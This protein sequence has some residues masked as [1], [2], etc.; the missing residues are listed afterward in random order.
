MK[1]LKRVLPIA[2]ATVMLCGCTSI[3]SGKGNAKNSQKFDKEVDVLVVG[4]GIA[5]LSAAVE[6]ADQGC[7][8][9]LVVEKMPVV[10]GSAFISD[11]IIAAHNSKMAK[12]QG[13][14]VT[15][16]DCYNYQMENKKYTI[17]AEMTKLT[18]EKA[19]ESIDWLM[20]VVKVP[21]EPEVQFKLGYSDLTINHIVEGG[22][23]GLREP[24]EKAL[25]ERTAIEL[26]TEAPATELIT[27]ENRN[28]IGAVVKTK[29]GEIRV[30]AKATILTTGGY[31]S[32]KDLFTRLY[33]KHE[34]VQEGTLAWAKGD[35]LIMASDLGAG[36][37]NGDAIQCYLREYEDKT[38]YT[39]N[40][41]N[42]FV[43]KDGT[44][45]MDERRVRQTFNKEIYED[46]VNQMYKDGVDYYWGIADHGTLSKFK[47][48]EEAKNKEGVFVADTLE[49][50]AEKIG[51]NPEGLVKTVANWNDMVAKGV[52]TEFGRTAMMMP[53]GEGPYYA[54]K[55][56]L[57]P[58][59]GHG[60]LMRNDKSEVIKITGESIPGLYAAGEVTG[61]A[62][63]N[64]YTISHC[65]TWG[66]IAAQ[67][68]AK[69]AKEG[70]A[71][72]TDKEGAG[73]E[74][75][76]ENEGEKLELKDGTYKGS[77]KGNGG[78]IAVEVVVEKSAIKD[79]KILEHKETEGLADPA[80]ERIPKAIIEAQSLEVDTVAGATV[81]SNAIKEAVKAA[82]GI[83]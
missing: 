82:L 36:I 25:K 83:K 69:Y 77:A 16:E 46:T 78:D 56:T 72:K 32:N 2:L 48:A 28:V 15:F 68:A 31:S 67:N 4:A 70:P 44:R 64:G 45:F 18:T 54:I 41:Y 37:V 27:D 26:M 23:K 3:G 22:G 14:D 35:G 66:R 7:E 76:K 57:S 24:F 29:D 50:L 10:G 13:I 52:D 75:K 65:I 55:S 21:F 47:I 81:T 6:L 1:I 20:D 11:G 49:E 73:E 79:I 42:I 8:N 59:L 74:E 9:V 80:L 51:V 53:I 71:E 60:G 30:G 19:G 34:V 61:A 40:M 62:N 38:G 63:A 43:G 58:T 39:N 12:D 5:G 33:P 17:D